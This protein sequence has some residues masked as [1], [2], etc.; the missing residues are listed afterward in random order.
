LVGEVELVGTTVLDGIMVSA[1]AGAV[2]LAGTM[3]SVGA[4]VLVGAGIMDTVGVILTLILIE[5][6]LLTEVIDILEVV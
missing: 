4:I 3:V 5:I 1:G 6:S 2:V